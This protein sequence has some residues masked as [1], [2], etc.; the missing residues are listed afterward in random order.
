MIE[1]SQVNH[2]YALIDPRTNEI[3]YVGKS[4]NVRKRLVSHIYKAR[5][6]PLEN[7]SKW[8][9][10]VI[11]NN[12]FPIVRIL[13]TCFGESWRQAEIYWIDSLRKSC[14]NLLNLDSGGGGFHD[15]RELTRD[16]LSKNTSKRMATLSLDQRRELT[17]N[18]R[19]TAGTP[20]RSS[21]LGE[22]M[23]KFLSSQSSEYRK[24]WVRAAIDGKRRFWKNGGFSEEQK[25]RISESHKN[26]P[27]EQR[28]RIAMGVS[29]YWKSLSPE[30]R[31]SK[32]DFL[33]MKRKEKR[34]KDKKKLSEGYNLP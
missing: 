5:H 12:L 7:K 8:I 14:C 11:D 3:R 32:I 13:E 21:K 10:D 20:E 25:L 23:K 6:T 26:P 29:N 31:K 30:E 19:K 22:T 4:S 2:I 1:S 33:Q 15:I 18:A 9:N 16:I 27:K 24:N 28:D 17:A 34:D